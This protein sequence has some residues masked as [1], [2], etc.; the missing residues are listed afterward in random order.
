MAADVPPYA[1][2]GGNPACVIRMRFPDED[3]ARL[4]ALA[5]WDWPI[6]RIGVNVRKLTGTRVSDVGGG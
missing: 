5:R 4:L 1:I 6:E 3:I 2:V